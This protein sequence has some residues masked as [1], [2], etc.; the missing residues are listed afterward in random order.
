[1]PASMISAPPGGSEKVSGNKRLI[2]ASGPSP[3]NS[4]TSMPTTQPVAHSSRLCMVSACSKPNSRLLMIWMWSMRRPLVERQLNA[5]EPLH[6]EGHQTQR[7][8]DHGG[9][10]NG[11]VI[12]GVA[13]NKRHNDDPGQHVHKFGDERE[14]EECA[15][16]QPNVLEVKI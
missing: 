8:G 1:M 10:S 3:G 14:A 4:P 16:D 13:G 15:G 7:G 9:A 5:E 11:K 6:R 2:V 12:A